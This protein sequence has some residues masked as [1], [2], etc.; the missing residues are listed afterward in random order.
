MVW[1]I[2][3]LVLNNH[4]LQIMYVWYIYVF[5]YSISKVKSVEINTNQSLTY[6]VMRLSKFCSVFD[7]IYLPALD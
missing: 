2:L 1:F 5:K 4:N 6:S 3:L 7:V